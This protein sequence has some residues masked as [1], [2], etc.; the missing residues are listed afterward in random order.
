MKTT[1]GR[2]TDGH[3]FNYAFSDATLAKHPELLATGAAP[4]WSAATTWEEGLFLLGGALIP[5]TVANPGPEPVTVSN[6]RLVNIVEECM[7]LALAYKMGNEGGGIGEQVDLRFNIDADVP[8]AYAYDPRVDPAQIP[9]T[10]PYFPTRVITIAPGDSQQISVTVGSL[11]RA[12][13]FDLALDTNT[14]VQLVRNGTS[15]FRFAPSLCPNASQ[16]SQMA[17]ADLAWMRGQL[18][19]NVRVRVAIAT[20]AAAEPAKY[21]GPCDAL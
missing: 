16:R 13:A 5:V 20:M 12:H 15:P 7:P 18:F 14:G 17:P 21:S 2:L 1:V 4:R 19:K 3:G 6:V 10:V 9:P 8:V 11:R